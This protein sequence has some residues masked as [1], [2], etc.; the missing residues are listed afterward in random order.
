MQKPPL[1]R[2]SKNKGDRWLTRALQKVK[3]SFDFGGDMRSVFLLSALILSGCQ[4]VDPEGNGG[5]D[6][7]LGGDDTLDTDNGGGDE[8]DTAVED[9]AVVDTAPPID[10]EYD[11]SIM[12]TADD[13]WVLWVNDTR[14]AEAEGWKYTDIQDSTVSLYQDGEH[15]IAIHGYDVYGVISGF[16]ASISLDGVPQSVTG[17]G[18]W[19]MS[20]EKPAPNWTKAQFDDSAWV[21]PELVDQSYV[22]AYWHNEP[23][24]LLDQGAQWVWNDNP[25]GL[26][27]V[28]FR[29]VFTIP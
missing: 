14:I 21:L 17:D 9:T 5:E 28:W 29:Y 24:D 7:N 13:A 6:D 10:S 2:S 25:R 16:V 11:L 18:Q 20:T 8:Q 23:S 15:V 4:S 3:R 12:L 19:L 27:E 26:G 1:F 22:S